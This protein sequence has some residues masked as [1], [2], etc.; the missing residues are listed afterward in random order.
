LRVRVKCAL[1]SYV[2]MPQAI[3]SLGGS[4][5][6]VVFVIASEAKQSIS[7]LDV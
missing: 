7:L 5:L 6:G 3:F 4:F 2:A 1:R